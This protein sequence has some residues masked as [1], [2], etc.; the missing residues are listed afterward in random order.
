MTIW[1]DLVQHHAALE[2]R[3]LS[4]IVLSDEHRLETCEIKLGG[5]SLNYALNH[6]T[7]DTMDLLIR[8]AESQDVA[9]WRERMWSG[10]KINFTESRAVLHVALRQQDDKPVMVDGNDVVPEIRAAQRRIADFVAAVRK[11]AY[12]GVTGK[13]IKNIINIGIGGSDLGPR[14]AVRALALQ[15]SVLDVHFVAN[16]DAFELLELLRRVDPAETLFLVVSKTFS[17]QETLL[18]AETARSWIKHH[19]GEQAITQHFVAVSTNVEAVKSFGI[20][21]QNVFPM[22]DW[23]GGRF[24]L[25]SAVGLSAALALGNEQFAELLR[26]AAAMDEHFRHTPFKKNLPVVLAMLGIWSHNFMGCAAHAVLPYSERLRELPRY[27][28]QLEM[29]S[30]GKSVTRDGLPVTLATAPILFGECG[31]VGQHSFHQWLHQGTDIASADFIGIAHDDLGLPQHH[32]ALL[33]NMTAQATA[34]AFGQTKA[35]AP[36]DVYA[37]NRPSTMLMLQK[38]D[39]Y[40]LGMLLALYEHKVFVQSIIWNI[41]PFDQP[42]V[43]LGKRMAKSLLSTASVRDEVG[44]FAVQLFAKILT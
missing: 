10:E 35:A 7:S 28:Q 18:N 17:T 24:S 20:A 39:P 43:E 31:T 25:W 11:G 23:V 27:L 26:G 2:A 40:H 38:L 6:V 15:V 36:Q 29:E 16:A 37:G 19:L 12:R 32:Q 44:R 8:L 33:S 1:E 22:W 14:L 3:P 41:N 9:G 30:N 21:S 5:L 34:F 13:R 42:G 4:D